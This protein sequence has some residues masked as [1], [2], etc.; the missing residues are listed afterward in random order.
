[1]AKE[2]KALNVPALVEPMVAMAASGYS[3]FQNNVAN[4]MFLKPISFQ[5]RADMKVLLVVAQL[6]T[7]P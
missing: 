5:M 6:I 2:V 1:L 3:I 7:R 4:L